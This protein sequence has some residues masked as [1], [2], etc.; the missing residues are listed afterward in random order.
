MN[1]APDHRGSGQHAGAAVT[2]PK[3]SFDSLKPLV[4]EPTACPVC[5]HD[6]AE[7]R[8]TKRIRE[9]TMH[10]VSCRHCN[11]LYANPRV[12]RASLPN[13]YASREFFEGKDDNINYY[14]FTG[15]EEYLS[16][17]A[18]AR[19][20]QIGKY[21]KG[22]RLL[23]VASAAGFFL[24]EAK[25]AGYRA[26]GI[27]ISRPMAEWASQRW[28]VPVRTSSIE[29]IEL[30]PES[31][32]VIASWGVFTILRDP[33]AVLRKFHAALAPGGTFAFNTYYN[34]SLWGRL[35]GANW[36]ILV[37]NTSQIHSP[38]TLASLLAE[39]GFCLVRRRREWPYAS[40]KYALFQ[41]A[42]HIPGAVSASWLDRIDVLN[43]LI[44]RVPAPDV[45]EY[46][47][48]KES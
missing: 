34:D 21:A 12:S 45:H 27:E 15:G 17:T 28:Q 6:D 38:D 29:D 24:K 44:I 10:Y 40:I 5:G 25:A 23:E 20:E 48:V 9:Y 32:D 3:P 8:Y 41:L 18:R 47:C 11:T 16:R 2:A 31:Y 37:L 42:S 4:F 30:P 43:H 36:Y 1:E 14:S 22:E 39:T 35:W 13:L 33:R 46:I 7:S 26:E 19:L